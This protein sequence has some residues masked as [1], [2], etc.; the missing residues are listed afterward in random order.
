MNIDI[1]KTFIYN[2]LY[3]AEM[4]KL[5]ASIAPDEDTKKTMLNFASDCSNHANYLDRFYQEEMT[6]SYHPIVRKPET[7]G[8]FK[9]TVFWMYR[10]EGDT[11]REFYI[12]SF[13]NLYTEQYRLL[14]SY[15]AGICNNHSTILNHIYLS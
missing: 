2:Q 10:F 12:S 15:I 1:L 6:S 7:H 3:A 8:S 11:Y 4:Y 9:D 13:N 5:L 14:L